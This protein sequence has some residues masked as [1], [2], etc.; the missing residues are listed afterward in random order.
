[1][2]VI[3][4]GDVVSILS[5]EVL[6][7]FRTTTLTRDKSSEERNKM[8]KIIGLIVSLIVFGIWMNIVGNPHV[9][10][11]VLGL[12][13]SLAVWYVI[14]KQSEKLVAKFRK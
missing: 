14:S 5:V 10:E 2:R 6:E 8:S 3:S 9:V 1:M 11:T 4:F 7:I 12:V 13:I